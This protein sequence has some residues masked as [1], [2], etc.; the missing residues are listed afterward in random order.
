MADA[1]RRG[2]P[3]AVIDLP[4]AAARE[5]YDCSLALIRP[6]QHVAWRGNALPSDCGAVLDRVSGF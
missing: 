3:L 1:K 4:D 6:D 5:L 2:L